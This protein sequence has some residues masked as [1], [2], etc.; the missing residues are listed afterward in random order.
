MNNGTP[1]VS[2]KV[3]TTHFFN[4]GGSVIL[5]RCHR[6]AMRVLTVESPG[7]RQACVIIHSKSGFVGV[8]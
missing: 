3:G 6:K 5:C 8:T 2:L 7:R 1:N 4:M